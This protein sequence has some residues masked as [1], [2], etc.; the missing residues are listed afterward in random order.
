MVFMTGRRSYTCLLIEAFASFSCPISRARNQR[1][2]RPPCKLIGRRE[3]HSWGRLGGLPR[4]SRR[5]DE[6]GESHIDSG[7]VLVAYWRCDRRA[8][9]RS[10]GSGVAY[11]CA[12]VF[13]TNVARTL[14]AHRRHQTS[15]ALLPPR[16]LSFHCAAPQSF[17]GLGLSRSC[18]MRLR[19]CE[20]G[21][22]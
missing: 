21:I 18:P 22:K 15:S 11:A 3:P 2:T 19:P 8:S 13:P 12:C 1:H 9:R 14:R 7:L 6:L 17:P 20:R 10:R 16:L 4:R 5:C